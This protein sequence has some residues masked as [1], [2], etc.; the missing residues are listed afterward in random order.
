MTK[1]TGL[2]A[3]FEQQPYGYENAARVMLTFSN[4]R[5]NVWPRW[6]P[7]SLCGLSGM[8]FDRNTSFK[9]TLRGLVFVWITYK[10]KNLTKVNT[11]EDC[12]SVEI[13]SEGSETNSIKCILFQ[14]SKEQQDTV[15]VVQEIVTAGQGFL[16]LPPDPSTTMSDL[17]GIVASKNSDQYTGFAYMVIYIWGLQALPPPNK[18]AWT[19]HNENPMNKT[20]DGGQQRLDGLMLFDQDN[21]DYEHLQMAELLSALPKDPTVSQKK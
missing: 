2:K 18:I 1:E 9:H 19:L 15:T 13:H 17:T 10:I 14:S 7:D 4:P 20:F 16:L 3:I 8:I 11:I 21:R 5:V 6:A 12:W